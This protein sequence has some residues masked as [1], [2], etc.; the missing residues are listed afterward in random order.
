M[1]VTTMLLGEANVSSETPHALAYDR[2]SPAQLD[3]KLAN[4]HSDISDR[5]LRETDVIKN[6]TG[7]DTFT[8]EHKYGA[9]YRFRNRSIQIYSGNGLPESYDDSNAFH[10]RPVIQL[11]EAVFSGKEKKTEIIRSLTTPEELSGFFNL[12]IK[13]YR[14]MTQR[15]TFTGELDTA[16][17][18]RDL[19]RRLSDPISCFIEDHLP[20]DYEA[21]V[22]KPEVLHYFRKYCKKR[23]YGKTITDT[24]FYID[25]KKKTKDFV[26]ESWYQDRDEKGQK[27]G[28]MHRI[29]KGIKLE[30]GDLDE[31]T[32]LQAPSN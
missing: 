30:L 14:K 2:F 11:F 7:G 31:Q 9:K 8:A 18:K 22:N 20:Q 27:V 10:K 19:Y 24:K 1:T 15:G 32:T 12:A 26:R 23:G 4:I 5:S 16:D 6:L 17:L 29:L 21:E 3:H 28:Q 25:F 13:A